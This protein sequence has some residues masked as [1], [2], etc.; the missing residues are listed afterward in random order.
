MTLAKLNVSCAANGQE[1]AQSLYKSRSMEFG[2]KNG[3]SS[4]QLHHKHNT[5]SDFEYD[6]GNLECTF[7][8]AGKSRPLSPLPNPG[9][10]YLAGKTA[11]KR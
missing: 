1:T 8:T 11:S 6:A 5:M 10:I 3:S 2:P 4:E 9:D 7:V